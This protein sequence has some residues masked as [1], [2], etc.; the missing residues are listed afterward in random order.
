MRRHVGNVRLS[1]RPVNKALRK[2]STPEQLRVEMVFTVKWFTS[3]NILLRVC[4]EIN[5]R[6]VFDIFFDVIFDMVFDKGYAGGVNF[7]TGV[8]WEDLWLHCRVAQDL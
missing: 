5:F 6:L 1:H 7:N 4:Y 2:L 8:G 3:R